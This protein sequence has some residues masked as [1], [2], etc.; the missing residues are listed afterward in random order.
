MIFEFTLSSL[1]L[2][3]IIAIGVFFACIMWFRRP[4]PGATPFSLFILTITA[5]L[6]LRLFQSATGIWETKI[7]LAEVMYLF[8]SGGVILWLI[9]A[10]EYC[11]LKTWRSPRNLLLLCAVPLISI[12]AVVTQPWHGIPWLNVYASFDDSGILVVWQRTMFYWVQLAYLWSVIIAGIVLLWKN[13]IQRQG[14]YRWQVMA[15]L[16]GTL[17]PGLGMILFSFG[18]GY[19]RGLDILPV[20]L[21]FGIIIYALA[22]F[23]FRL[24]NLVPVA[25]GALVEIMPDGILVLNKGQSVMDINPA[26]E[27][28]LGYQKTKIM[29]QNIVRLWPRIECVLDDFEPGKQIEITTEDHRCL[30]IMITELFDSRGRRIGRLL[31][32]R[33]ISERRKMENKL[34]ESEIRYTT[35]VEQ[36]NEAV[37]MIQDGV[38]KFVNRT[39]TE[40]TGFS[41]EEIIGK[42]FWQLI[43]DEDRAMVEEKH[44]QRM[45]GNNAPHIYEV[46]LKCKN[47]HELDVELSV[48]DIGET[49]EAAHIITARDIT[50]RKVT[51]RKLEGLYQAEKK[52]R[53][54]LQEEMEKKN[55]YT[56]ALVHELNTPLTAILASGEILETETEEP[57]L[58]ALVK[59]I[60]RA[61]NNLKQRIDELIELARGEIG[62]LKINVMPLDMTRL[63]T[64]M[65]SEMAPLAQGKGLQMNLDIRGELP[66]VM[67]D[68]SRLRQVMFNLIGNAVKF[69][70]SGTITVTGETVN[71]HVQVNVLDTG[72]GIG[73]EEMVNLFDPYLR[74]VNEGQELGGLGIGLALSKMFIDLHG[75]K[76]EVNSRLGEGS[77]FRFSVPV[78]QQGN[79]IKKHSEQH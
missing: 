21:L 52:L 5:W 24:L 13:V 55:R 73:R 74:K 60:R 62:I 8:L 43:S 67:G 57:T 38:V 46:K 58:K 9:F 29:G 18:L 1:I 34:R 2:L 30:D 23:R 22:I 77:S 25:R 32:L 16:A 41:R 59:N 28:I 70:Q 36:S 66:L 12:L 6:F 76:I 68:R 4:S 11:G 3:V 51:R 61:S 14:V 20:V 75:G 65:T 49:G 64:E 44:I 50:E 79:F 7:I 39:L 42:P 33:D 54:I 71:G 45:A 48:G 78:Y 19:F 63:L 72:R 26:A 17:I 47:G 53:G 69:T 27:K 15:L 10:S 35:L 40:I 31:V 56:R 37:W